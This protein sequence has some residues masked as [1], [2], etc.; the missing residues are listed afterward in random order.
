MVQGC[1]AL[2]TAESFCSLFQGCVVFCK[3]QTQA[4]S[5]K[6][7]FTENRQRNRRDANVSGPSF[8]E[9]DIVFIADVA[10]VDYLKEGA[11]RRQ[12]PEA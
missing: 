12:Q 3:T 4:A 1:P 11:A 10:I 8:G 5:G 6:R 2:D 7:C 9:R